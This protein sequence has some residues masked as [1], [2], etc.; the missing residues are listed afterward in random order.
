[1]EHYKNKIYYKD[2][3]KIQF[4][5]SPAFSHYL[6]ITS[7]E[8]SRENAYATSTGFIKQVFPFN[9]FNNT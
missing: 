1:M 5:F 7:T 4:G 2:N 8:L 3:Q 9:R 6:F